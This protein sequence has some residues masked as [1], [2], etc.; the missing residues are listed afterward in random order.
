MKFQIRDLADS[1]EAGIISREQAQRLEAFLREKS[2][3]QTGFQITHILYYLGGLIAIG[4]MTLF[5]TLG[6]EHFGGLGILLIASCY[7]LLGLVLADFFYRRKHLAIP[8][9]IMA[10]FVIALTPL[11]VYGFQAAMGLWT[12]GRV[13]RDYY[14]FIDWRWFFMQCATLVVGVCMLGRYRLPFLVMPIAVT[15]W[16]MTMDIV[17]LFFSNELQ[18][19]ELRLWASLW[20]GLLILVFAFWV[21]IRSRKSRDFAFW[22]YLFGTISFWSGLSLMESDSELSKFFYLCINLAMIFIGAVI[23]RKVFVVFG[24]LGSMGYLGHLAYTVFSDSVLF[25]FILSVIG[26]G[27]IFLGI[28]WQ[29][30]DQR[31]TAHLRGYLPV[32]MREWLQSRH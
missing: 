13:Y 6:W 12:E 23:V 1:V 14:S 26:L 20:F 15:L 2:G 27:I 17:P 3:L 8:A 18:T 29:K 30:N 9:G 19:W 31:I 21:D 11:A 7:A 10:T 25:P 5:M 24:A 22:L 16:F 4:A 32:V 28:I